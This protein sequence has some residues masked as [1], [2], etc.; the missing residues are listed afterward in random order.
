MHDLL[1]Q[2]PALSITDWIQPHYLLE[3]F[4]GSLFWLGI[5]LLIIECGLFFPFLPGDT[6]LFAMGLFIAFGNTRDS[7]GVIQGLNVIPGPTWLDLLFVI[8][9]YTAAAFAGNVIGYEIGR[10]IGPAFYNHTGKIMKR[11]YLDETQA[12]FDKH[13][14]PALIIG[15]FVPLVRTYVTV[16]A[17]ITKMDRR[18]F[19]VY[20]FV[21][22]ASWVASIT[23][24][25]FFLGKTFPGLGHY[26]DLITYGLL[27]VTVLVLAFEF[28]R[29]KM[30]GPKA[31]A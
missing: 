15:R 31:T 10:K 19:F 23:L 24:V 12:F 27:A 30:S 3:Q 8:A 14:S 20:S 17:G 2:L 5:I 4:G 11:E 28:L 6:L 29:K 22:A 13:G 21:G 7:K 1:V 9:I 25:G 26:I 16:V 18:A